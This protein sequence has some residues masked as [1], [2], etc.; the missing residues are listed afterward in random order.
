[1]SDEGK[2]F[3]NDVETDISNQEAIAENECCSENVT[4]EKPEASQKSECT[5]DAKDFKDK[6]IDLLK[7]QLKKK[8]DELKTYIELAQRVKAEFENYK[9]RTLK[10]KEQLYTDTSADIITKLLPVVDNMERALSSAMESKDTD[11]LIEGLEMI[12]KQLKDILSKEG[13]EEIPAENEQFDPNFHNAVMH[14]EDESY[15]SNTI[16]EVFQKGYK[17]KDKILRYSMVKV[18]N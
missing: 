14:V 8:D 10:E 17:I 18:A 13:V 9:K 6:E 15:S 11:K 1:M 7:I 4:E 3:E 16:A 12:S 5:E 2:I